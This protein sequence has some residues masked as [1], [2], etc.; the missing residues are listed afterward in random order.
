MDTENFNLY[1]QERELDALM[2]EVAKNAVDALGTEGAHHK[3]YFAQEIHR[4]V[5]EC[6]AVHHGNAI[7]P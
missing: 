6:Y 2:V 1:L 7:A 5:R 4:L 3:R